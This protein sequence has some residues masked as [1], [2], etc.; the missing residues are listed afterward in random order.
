MSDISLPP[1]QSKQNKKLLEKKGLRALLLLLVLFAP[2][3]ML[4]ALIDWTQDQQ[5]SPFFTIRELVQG[6]GTPP[7]WLVAAALLPSL[8]AILII[9]R[10]AGQRLGAFVAL[11]VFVAV[12]VALF[13]QLQA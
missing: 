2:L 3:P 11:L 9:G 5:E 12:E 6:T 8:I 4:I 13:M 10:T 1:E 7:Y